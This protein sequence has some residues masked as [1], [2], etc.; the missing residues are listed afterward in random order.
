MNTPIYDTLKAEQ[1]DWAVQ[2]PRYTAKVTG[3]F[4]IAPNPVDSPTR[5]PWPLEGTRIITKPEPKW[6]TFLR[7]LLWWLP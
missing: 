7:C 3:S 4:D 5:K 2:Y 1:Y 6:R